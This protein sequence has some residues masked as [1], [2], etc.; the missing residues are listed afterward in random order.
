MF[1]NRLVAA[2]VSSATEC[3]SRGVLCVPWGLKTNYVPRRS[4]SDDALRRL[5][6][7]RQGVGDRRRRWEDFLGRPRDGH[8]GFTFWL[9]YAP[10]GKT[11]A[12]SGNDGTIR[13]W[14]TDN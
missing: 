1:W 3:R 10:D 6:A 13:F 8:D 2:F 11:L 9:Q 5:L 4:F 7:G 12:T 14:R